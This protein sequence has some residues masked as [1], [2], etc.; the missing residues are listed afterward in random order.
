MVAENDILTP[1][2]LA[3]AGFDRAREPKK[4][5]ILPG[6]HFDAYVSGFALSSGNAIAWY[7]QWL[8]S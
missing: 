8:M 4:L 2:D 7:K 3:I 5:V 6:G 1:T